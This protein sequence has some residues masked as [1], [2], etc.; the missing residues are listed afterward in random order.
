M[1]IHYA[2]LV[3]RYDEVHDVLEKTLS[4]PLDVRSSLDKAIK[5]SLLGKA[6]RLSN[7]L[8]WQRALIGG[9]LQLSALLNIHVAMSR[10]V[11]VTEI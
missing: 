11:A 5:A 9:D 10:P 8:L 4:A 6:F 1:I 3:I 7:V 2:Y